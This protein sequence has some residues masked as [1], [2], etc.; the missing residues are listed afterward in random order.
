MNQGKIALG[1]MVL[2]VTQGCAT[3]TSTESQPISVSTESADGSRVEKAS[4]TLKNDKGAWT[5]ESPGFVPV[6]RSAED[7]LVECSKEG[8]PDGFLRAISRAAAGMFG[9]IIFGGGIGA[10][11]DHSKG[12]GYDYPSSLAVKMGASAV[13]DRRNEQNAVAPTTA[14]ADAEASAAAQSQWPA[15]P[16]S[17]REW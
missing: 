12:T 9:N 8:H 3:I 1:T 17:I 13:V 11:I 15:R 6:H 16:K 7:L 2:V 5:M 10:L 4:C 14:T